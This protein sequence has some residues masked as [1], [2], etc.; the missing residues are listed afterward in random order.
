M[1]W[2]ALD[3][4]IALASRIEAEGRVGDWG[5]AR[6]EIRAAILYPRLECTGAPE[7][8]DRV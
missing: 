8:L 7:P 5:T 2:V 4:A 1:C 6:D 3:G